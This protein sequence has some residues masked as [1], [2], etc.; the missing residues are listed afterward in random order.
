[1]TFG[2]I[3]KRTFYYYAQSDSNE[4]NGSV[5]CDGGTVEVVCP[6]AASVEDAMLMYLL[7]LIYPNFFIC[8]RLVLFTKALSIC[9]VND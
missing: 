6:L 8:H 9:H 7:F 4:Y 3:C 5:V 1:M 2:V